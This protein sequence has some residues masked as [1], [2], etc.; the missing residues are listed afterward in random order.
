[1]AK[2]SIKVNH[3]RPLESF[4]ESDVAVTPPEIKPSDA[5]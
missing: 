3:K 4:I 5:P 2:P 1:M